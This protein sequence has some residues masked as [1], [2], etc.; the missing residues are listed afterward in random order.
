MV[1]WDVMW[2][3]LIDCTSILEEPSASFFRVEAN[4]NMKAAGSYEM[5]VPIYET[6]PLPISGDHNCNRQWLG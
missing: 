1:F 6:A 2:C 3:S 5:L 4:L